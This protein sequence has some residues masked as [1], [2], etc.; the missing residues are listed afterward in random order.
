MTRLKIGILA[1]MFLAVTGVASA[2][3]C[4]AGNVISGNLSIGTVLTAPGV[5]CE[6]GAYTFSTFEVTG[7]AGYNNSPFQLNITG[8]VP[9]GLIFGYNGGAGTDFQLT[10]NIVGG[11]SG[12]TLGSNS[13]SVTELI[14]SVVYDPGLAQTC[15][16][17][18]G[19]ILGTG[20]INADY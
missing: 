13:A 12:M 5:T 7:V 10:Y 17:Q 8:T 6:V 18:G 2:A 19:T 16:G 15:S 3:P 20:A 11:I 9:N 1:L 14:C 4:V